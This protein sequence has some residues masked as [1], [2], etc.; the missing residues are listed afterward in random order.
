MT[1]IEYNRWLVENGAKQGAEE[2]KQTHDEERKLRQAMQ[3]KY[4][5]EEESLA[6]LV[7]M[8]QMEAP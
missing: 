4:G 8:Q 2:R 6:T 7:D 5:Y 1:T 3:D